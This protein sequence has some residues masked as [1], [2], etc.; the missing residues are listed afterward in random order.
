MRKA[1][2]AA[3]M[4]VGAVVACGTGPD[5]TGTLVAQGAPGARLPHISHQRRPGTARP[6]LGGTEAASSGSN[7]I[8]VGSAN[9]TKCSKKVSYYCGT[10][11]RPLDPSGA[12][13]G[14]IDIHYEWYPHTNTTPAT[15]TIVAIE[16]G[17]GYG[18]TESR[19]YYL[20]AFAPLLGDRDMVLVDARGTGLSA[21]LNCP[22]AQTDGVVTQSDIA[23]CG[24]TL[25]TSADLYGSDLAA[26]DMEAILELLD[27]GLIDLYGD[28]YGTYSAQIFAGNF[29]ARIRTITLDA[30]YPVLHADPFFSPEGAGLRTSF[31]NVCARSPD[32]SGT[33]TS[34]VQKVVDL[35]RAD[36]SGAALVVRG[37]TTGPMNPSDLG[38]SE[39]VAGEEYILYS[40]YDPSLV[41]Y[42]AGDPLPLVRSVNEQWLNEE[43]GVGTTPPE[44]SMGTL[45]A[46]TC[47]D[48]PMAYD[49]TLP[50]GPARQA[51]YDWA[52]AGLEHTNPDVYS[53]FSISEWLAT[54]LDWS[55]TGLC[56]NWP[57]ASRQ[58]PEGHP[59]PSNSVPNV[60]ALVLT[61][62][63]DTVTPVGE[64]DQTAAEFPHV[65]RVI[66]YNGTHVTALGDPTGCISGI[67]D[68]FMLAG[69]NKGLKTACAGNATPPFRVVP[70]FALTASDVSLRGV[71]GN[72]ASKTLQQIARAAVLTAN[73]SYTRMYNLAVASGSG[74]RGGTFNS[75]NAFTKVTLKGSYWTTD[76][77]VSGPVEADATTGIITATLTLHD[78]AT[79]SITAVWDPAGPQGTAVV[80]GTINGTS[81]NISVPAP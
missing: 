41:S 13:S 55:I 14:T 15:G 75:N 50:P 57:V 38:Y 43:G 65:S 78:V 44:F 6:A 32:C 67:V 73:D 76:L 8:T 36:P 30:A 3:L 62:D 48:G 54:P 23:A 81:V 34:K 66:V 5:A 31:D 49:M 59:I 58:H 40:E 51:T 39:N 18:S 46:N 70:E 7:S 10:L 16:G 56:L 2:I 27:I 22:A 33:T 19:D 71:T 61:G 53:P 29:P 17:P 64:G 47:Q 77:K 72:G 68:A 26:D 69:T 74:L 24:T 4:S 80:T 9:L 35:L 28:S 79:G 25:G 37:S 12:V 60:P 63:L 45:I 21:A 20:G 52:I 1:W 11:T 42:L